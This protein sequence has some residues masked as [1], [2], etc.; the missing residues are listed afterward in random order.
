MIS[1]FAKSFSVAIIPQ[2]ELLQV[3]LSEDGTQFII[4]PGGFGE[5]MSRASSLAGDEERNGDQE[6]KKPFVC[7]LCGQS[8]TRRDNL[9][10]HIKVRNASPEVCLM[11]SLLKVFFITSDGRSFLLEM[12]KSNGIFFSLPVSSPLIFRHYIYCSLVTKCTMDAYIKPN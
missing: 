6:H 3:D 10:N 9:A 11:Y 8:F 2:T 1:Q 4:G 7:P 12:I 5:A